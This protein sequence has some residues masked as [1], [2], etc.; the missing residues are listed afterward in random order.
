MKILKFYADW[1]GPCKMLSQTIEKYYTGDVE[2]ESVDIDKDQESAIKFGIRG[3]PTCVLIDDN[4]AE[5][6]RVS[7]M[8]MIDD[9]EKFIKGE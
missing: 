3:V 4:G 8:M 2:I 7:G 6:R 9:F 5:L 1:C